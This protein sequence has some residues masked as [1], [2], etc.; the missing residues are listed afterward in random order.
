MLISKR[1]EAIQR[2]SEKAPSYQFQCETSYRYAYCSMSTNPNI[3]HSSSNAMQAWIGRG[4]Q[5]SLP[6][7]VRP[8]MGMLVAGNTKT[9]RRLQAR[10]TYRAK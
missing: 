6:S 3:K 5:S 2:Q 9:N 7:R 10:L 4:K 1:E 8:V